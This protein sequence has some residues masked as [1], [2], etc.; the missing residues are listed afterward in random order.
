MN[1]PE[2]SIL[3][4]SLEDEIAGAVLKVSADVKGRINL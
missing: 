1:S 3:L 4:S 2:L